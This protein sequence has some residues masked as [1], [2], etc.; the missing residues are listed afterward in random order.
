MYAVESDG[1][2]RSMTGAA[3]LEGHT[4]NDRRACLPESDGTR[5]LLVDGVTGYYYN[6]DTDVFTTTASANPPWRKDRRIFLAG[7]MVCE[8]QLFRDS[9]DGPICN[10]D[11][12]GRL[13]LLPAFP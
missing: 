12:V 9:F 13:T 6:M 7:R 5:I 11:M 10:A 2:Y 4:V 1:F 3:V 8:D